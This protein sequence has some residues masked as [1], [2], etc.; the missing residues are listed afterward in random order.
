MTMTC[1]Q[2]NTALPAGVTF[3]GAC[4]FRMPPPQQQ[5]YPPPQQQGYPP[6]QQQGYPPPQQQGYPPPQPQSSMRPYPLVLHQRLTRL[7]GHIVVAPARL[8]FVCSSNKG[9][10]TA[11]IGKGIGA[12][13]GGIIG[14]VVGAV[15]EGSA[16][17]AFG[18]VNAVYDEPTLF[19]AVQEAQGSLVMEPHQVKQIKDTFW[20]HGIWFNGL[21]YAIRSSL[22]KEL[23]RELGLWCQ[24]HNV[25]Q[26]GLLK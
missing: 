23:K 26:A 2:C 11:A 1:P 17:Q 20:T 5:G 10:L 4:G 16:A 25:K 19:R 8:F 18:A 9:G 22:D 12:G 7:T 21:T 14:G 3:C 15:V 24:Q 13:V 6:P